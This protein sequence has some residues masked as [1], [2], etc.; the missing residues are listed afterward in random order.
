MQSEFSFTLPRGYMDAQGQVHRT[1]S[2][3]LARAIDEIAPLSD[4]RVHD[5]EAYLAVLLL[6]RVVT[7]LGT[8]SEVTEETIENL[9]SADMLYLQALYE[10]I[11]E[12]TESIAITCPECGHLLEI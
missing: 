5:N 3:R 8:L 2:M 6:A 7:Q 4:P 10:R 11:N 9:Y 12:T 1:G